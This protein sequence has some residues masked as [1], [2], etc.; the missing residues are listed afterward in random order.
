MLDSDQCKGYCAICI[1]HN[2]CHSLENKNI[3]D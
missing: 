3:R 1:C 2:C